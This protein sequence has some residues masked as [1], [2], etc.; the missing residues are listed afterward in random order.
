ME[1]HIVCVLSVVR[2]E[3]GSLLA[4]DTWV[5]GLVMLPVIKHCDDGTVL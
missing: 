2:G 4:L 5:R 1:C 3:E